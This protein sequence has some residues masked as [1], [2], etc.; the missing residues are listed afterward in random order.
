MRSGRSFLLIAFAFLVIMAGGGLPAPLYVVYQ[1]AWGFSPGILTVVFAAY[2]VGLLFAL[3]AFRNASDRLGRKKVLLVGVL[4]ALA[5]TGVFLLAQN[6]GWLIVAR[7]LSGASTGLCASTATAALTE[8]EP[9][10]DRRRATRWITVITALGVGVGP[11]Y[12]GFLIQYGPDPLTLSFW[13]LFALL[14]AALVAVVLAHD[15]PHGQSTGPPSSGGLF[16]VPSA[17]RPVFFLSATAAFVGFTL[18]GLFSGLAPSFLTDDLGITNHALAGATVLLMFGSAALAQ[19]WWQAR[20]SALVLQIGAT[21]APVALALIAIAVVTGV[22]APFFLGTVLCGAGFGLC[23][24]GGLGML[25]QVAPPDRRGAVLSGF[26]V[27]AYLGLSAPIVS[28]G[29]LA[30]SIGL[31][32]AV[33]LLAVAI[34][35]LSVVG[36]LTR[37]AL[38]NASQRVG[39]GE[40]APPV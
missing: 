19:L 7:L 23:L 8:T 40:P 1:K 2:A 3:V 27:A 24:L 32:T 22:P 33:V 34:S 31:P 18:A 16:Q 29:V 25:N 15:G 13:V 20:R 9:S 4:V 14:L 17:I 11:F 5:S 6:V 21:I 36:I 10:G 39:G 28:I 26:Y 35:L 12:A 30:D 37:R 38:R